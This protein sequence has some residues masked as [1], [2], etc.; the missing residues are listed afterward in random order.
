MATLLGSAFLCDQQIV[1]DF[2]K[3]MQFGIKGEKDTVTWGN[4]IEIQVGHAW[5]MLGMLERTLL[6]CAGI[7]GF[8]GAI[9]NGSHFHEANILV[10]KLNQT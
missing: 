7:L 2:C 8:S 6:I 4:L 3:G 10:S 9:C 1:I 5:W